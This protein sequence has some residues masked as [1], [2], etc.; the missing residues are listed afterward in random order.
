MRLRPHFSVF[1]IFTDFSAAACSSVEMILS[2]SDSGV[3]GRQ[4]KIKSYW[5]SSICPRFF[6]YQLQ[7]PVLLRIFFARRHLAVVAQHGFLCAFGDNYLRRFRCFNRR[8]LGAFAILFAELSQQVIFAIVPDAFGL[9]ADTD[10][11]K[12]IRSSR[13]EK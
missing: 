3:S 2:I 11:N 7:K 4:M 6:P 1:S 13:F 10:A 9:H 12:L 8:L 5:R